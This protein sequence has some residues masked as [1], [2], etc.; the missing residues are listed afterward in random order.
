[1][2]QPSE[3]ITTSYDALSRVTLVHSSVLG[4]V[5]YQYDAASRRTEMQYPDGFYVTYA[6]NTASDLTG[7]L[8]YGSTTLATYAYD[9]LGRRTSLTRGNGVVTSYSYDALSRLATL[10][11]NASGSSYDTTFTFGYNPASQITSRTRTNGVYDWVLPAGANDSYTADGLNR[12]TSAAGTSPTYDTRG[13]LTGDGSM[14]YAYDYDN[15]LT[16][17]YGG[18]SLDYDPAGR[19]HQVAGATTTRFLYDGADVIAEYNSGGTVLRRYVHGPGTDEPLVWYEGSGTADRRY[20]IADERGSVIGVTNN[21]GTVTQVDRYDAYGVPDAANQGRFQYTGQMWIAELGLYHYKARAYHPRFGRFLQTDPIGVGGGINLYAYGGNDAVNLVDPGGLDPCLFGLNQTWATF[22]HSGDAAGGVNTYSLGS[23]FV[24]LIPEPP[25]AF[26]GPT[27]E[28][29]GYVPNGCGGYIPQ[30]CPGIGGKDGETPQTPPQEQERVDRCM[31]PTVW[32]K[33]AK[34]FDN[35][36]AV[37]QRVALV[38]G[39]LALVSS[40]T[41]VGGVAFGTISAGAESVTMVS[42]AASGVA[43]FADRNYRGVT[44]SALSLVVSTAI[45]LGMNRFFRNMP[46]SDAQIVEV[47][48]YLGLNASFVADAMVDEAVCGSHH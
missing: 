36:A 22:T 28:Q 4:D 41:V 8:E 27:L 11:Q 43:N 14:T 33:A 47:S 6:Y 9:N 35:T 2:S 12:Y 30:A 29:A 3:A 44:R 25:G 19:L 17:A 24:C 13:N 15:R 48:Q 26:L 23:S 21:S 38:S 10:G 34:I 32:S 16:S 18:V 20:L 40:E 37:S 31:R 46:G 45:P 5:S 42:T 1:M 7:I 39:G